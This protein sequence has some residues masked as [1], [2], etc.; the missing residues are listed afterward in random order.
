MKREEIVSYLGQDW[1]NVCSLM[2]DS[3]KTDIPLL[4]QTNSNILS[5]SGKMLRPMTS[6]LSAKA[7]TGGAISN[8][9]LSYAAA[10]ELLHNATLLHDDVADQSPT[11]RG[12]PTTM[13]LLGPGAAVL[14]GDFWL[15]RA[16]S[17]I[18]N[19]QTRDSVINLFSQTLS[20]LAEG[21]MLQLQKASLADTSMEDYLR[22]IYCKTASLFEASCLSGAISVGA[23]QTQKEAV[24]Q[25]AISLGTAFQIKDD[26]LDYDGSADLGKPI[27]SDL[28]EQKITLPLLLAL[29]GSS[30]EAE[31]RD[32]VSRIPS[33]PEYVSRIC[34][35]V[36][37]NSGIQKSYEVLDSYVH[38]AIEALQVL[39]Q[40][41]AR[42]CLQY[43]AEY[44]T[45]RKA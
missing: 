30:R 26:I 20:H 34:D 25:Y 29:Q 1:Q 10:S 37:E 33:H 31:I 36:R 43:I 24:R 13:S 39:P 8:D 21:E 22:I 41:M 17:T 44:N 23:D 4:D 7:I 5:H 14:I 35:F 38:K 18:M 32:M 11:R 2:R 28:H 9:T 45:S 12:N 6:L 27:G 15:S 42:E 16:V 40:S 19:A 3:L